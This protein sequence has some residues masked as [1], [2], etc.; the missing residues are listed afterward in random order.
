MREYNTKKKRANKDD[1]SFVLIPCGVQRNL[2]LSVN[3]KFLW[4]LL[5]TVSKSIRDWPRSTILFFYYYWINLVNEHF[6]RRRLLRRPIISFLW[7]DYRVCNH[8]YFPI[9]HFVAVYALQIF[10][11]S[12]SSCDSRRFRGFHCFWLFVWRI[13]RLWK[14]FTACTGMHS[15][16]S[17][18][19]SEFN[20]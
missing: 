4:S 5:S 13:Q 10:F 6:D 11:S 8:F 1:R 3:E 2:F 7:F 18:G 17:V 9:F 15:F 19:F 20:V 16:R 12:S 14:I